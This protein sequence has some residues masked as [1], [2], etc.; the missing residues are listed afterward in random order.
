MTVD[1]NK[2]IKGIRT[3]I[4]FLQI[5]LFY[6]IKLWFCPNFTHRNGKT[7]GVH[8]PNWGPASDNTERR[9]RFTQTV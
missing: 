6:K 8:I 5:Y 4:F 3:D 7:E 9:A 2:T 1:L